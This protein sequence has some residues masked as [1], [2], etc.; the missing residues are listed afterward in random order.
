MSK[1]IILMGMLVTFL[2]QSQA[3]AA[4]SDEAEQE[5]LSRTAQKSLPNKDKKSESY[6][7]I[8]S[9]QEDDK[10]KMDHAD[11]EREILGNS[12]RS[13]SV[14]VDT[15]EEREKAEQRKKEKKEKMK[16]AKQAEQK[17]ESADGTAKE[18]NGR[19]DMYS[20]S[21]AWDNP[22]VSKNV[23]EEE[24]KGDAGSKD[25]KSKKKAKKERVVSQADRERDI[26]GSKGNRTW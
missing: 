19:Q 10:V 20:S 9:R 23:Q 5:I 1:K 22:N 7:V 18:E 21:M 14:P 16:K 2:F 8:W 4:T 11:R 24:V 3:I 6:R 25:K 15:D 26:L 12:Q 13:V 17:K